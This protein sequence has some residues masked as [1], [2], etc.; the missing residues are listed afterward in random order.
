MPGKGHQ[1]GFWKILFVLFKVTTVWVYTID[2]THRTEHSRP[3]LYSMLIIA[4]YKCP[5]ASTIKYTHM[6]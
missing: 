5:D 3:I 1:V 6:N 4:K 2:R